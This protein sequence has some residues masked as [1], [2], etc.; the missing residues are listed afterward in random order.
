MDRAVERAARI[1]E[2][3]LGLVEVRP[4]VAPPDVVET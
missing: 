1:P 2:A 4:L 3:T